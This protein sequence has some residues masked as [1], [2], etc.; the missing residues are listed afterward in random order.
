MTITD[1][2]R[3]QWKEEALAQMTANQKAKDEELQR[4]ELALHLR[5]QA[6]NAEEKETAKR[7]S[8]QAWL[9]AGGTNANFETHWEK[10]YEDLIYQRALK[11]MVSG[12]TPG[13][14]KVR[15]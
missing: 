3:E 2:Q 13:G 7:K 14:F 5:A 12:E 11:S 6:K 1:K 10:F 4:Q 9:A 15:F 8:R